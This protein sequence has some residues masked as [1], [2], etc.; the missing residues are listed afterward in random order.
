LNGLN[1][2]GIETHET[3]LINDLSGLKMAIL[4]IANLW[5][6]V[7]LN[8]AFTAELDIAC[9]SVKS[10]TELFFY[11]VVGTRHHNSGILNLLNHIW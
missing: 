5:V 6:V 3:E 10:I 4:V 11:F 8:Y 7:S 1:P 9:I 2:S